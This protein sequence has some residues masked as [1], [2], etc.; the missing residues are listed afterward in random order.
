MDVKE[1]IIIGGGVAGLSAAIRLAELGIHALVLEAGKY[2]G[3]RIC[4]EFFSP[5]CLPILVN[6]GIE[7]GATIEKGCF[8]IGDREILF[9]LPKPAGGISR[10]LFDMKLVE[11]ARS[12][13][14]EVRTEAI[15]S[16]LKITDAGPY[17][18]CLSDGTTYY[19]HR[20]MIGTGRLPNLTEKKSPVYAGFKA[21]FEGIHNPQTIEMHCF[22]GGYVG[23]SPISSDVTNVAALVRLNRLEPDF[24]ENLQRKK[25]MKLFAER[26][27]GSRMIFSQWM[28]GQIPEFGI[29]HNP[30]W[31]NVYWIGD[32]AGSIPPIC[33]DGLAIALTTGLMAADYLHSNDPA[34]YQKAWHKRYRSRFFW[35]KCLHSVM[36]RSYLSR[37][38]VP[39]CRWIP[40]LP[41]EVFSLTR[42]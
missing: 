25:G 30:P 4:G 9:S 2:P 13:G 29:R 18:V 14:A 35:G 17:E 32:A 3:H 1:C 24:M 41:A 12:K 5:E 21:H 27:Q 20:L 19:S 36:A 38:A 6:W 15:V 34:G 31:P 16:S 39:C 40:S 10:Y 42:E 23:I 26:M 22:D 28:S 7:L 33:G 11:I 8:V 37:L